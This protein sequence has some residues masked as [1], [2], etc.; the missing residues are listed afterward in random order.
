MRRSL[1]FALCAFLLA[2][3]PAT[4]HA[5]IAPSVDTIVSTTEVHE[6]NPPAHLIYIE[7]HS[8]VPVEVF[9]IR[10]TDC[11]NI[12]EQCGTRN[13]H[14][15][16]PAGNRVIAVRVEPESKERGF[17]YR[18]GFSWH[19]DSS[20]TQALTALATAGDEKAR[21][22]LSAIQHADSL[23][24]SETGA[25]YNDLSRTDFAALASRVA[26]MR[27]YPESLVLAPG[28]RTTIE[29]I[30]LLLLDNQ[31]VVLGQTRWVGW[32]VENRGP[33]EFLPPNQINA[34]RPGRSV[35]RFSLAEE[36]QKALAAL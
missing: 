30:R 2:C 3:A 4:Q 13:T 9:S 6:A 24:R 33:I 20:Y 26:S 5:Y 12:R 19:E 36:A 27:A 7:N 22:Q 31:G 25:H 15:R 35:I 23:R 10:L 29:R 21:V 1:R 14:L 34:K 16:V 32:R 18:F 8:T 28:E 17:Y 11:Q